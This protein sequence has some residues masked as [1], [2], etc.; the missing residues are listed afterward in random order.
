MASLHALC[1]ENPAREPDR[2][3]DEDDDYEDPDDCHGFSFRRS[4]GLSSPDRDSL[5]IDRQV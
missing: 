3:Q 1:S 5:P 2:E 4:T